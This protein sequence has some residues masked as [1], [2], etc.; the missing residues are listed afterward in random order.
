MKVW[1]IQSTENNILVKEIMDEALSCPYLTV[2]TVLTKLLP[3]LHPISTL[4]DS[5][6]FEML[7]QTL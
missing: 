7:L 6:N 3:F 1:K 2:T 5:I 4:Q